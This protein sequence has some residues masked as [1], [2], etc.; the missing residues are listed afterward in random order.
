[1]NEFANSLRDGEVLCNLANQIYPGCIDLTQINKRS[2]MSQLLCLNNIRL[3]LD[4]CKS[5]QYFCLNESD[6]FDEHMLYDLVDL[7]C[8]IR[9]LSI[10]SNHK[11]TLKKTNITGFKLGNTKLGDI[12]L[13]L[14]S[15]LPI[16]NQ[17]QPQLQNQL[18][19]KPISEYSASINTNTTTTTNNNN[20]NDDIYYNIVPTEIES[21]ESFYTDDSFIFNG[22]LENQNGQS[23]DNSVY[24]TI[25]QSPTKQTT[26]QP[27]KRD[28]VIKEILNTEENFVDGLNTLMDDFL[29][30]LSKILNEQDRKLICINLDKLINLHKNLY[31]SLFNACKGGQGRTQ[32]ICTVFESFKVDL[33]KEYAEYFSNIDR[34]IAKCDSLTQCSL[35]QIND[36]SKQQYI[37]DFRSKLEECRKQSK[38]GNFKLTDLL[39]LPYQRVLKYH[40]LFN[41][42][43]KQ[44]DVEHSAKDIIKQTKE[45]MCE[46]GNYLNECQRDKEN[47][48]N[49]EQLLKHLL[50]ATNYNENNGTNRSSFGGSSSSFYSNGLNLNLL[51]DFGHYIKDD[52]L[53]IKSIDLGERSARTRTF[54]LFEKALIVCKLKG[55]YYNYKE[56]LIM[57]EYNI[58]DPQINSNQ[59]S[60]HNII[61]NLLSDLN[62]NSMNSHSNLSQ[63]NSSQYSL[64]LINSDRSKINLI[65]FKNKEQKKIWKQCLLMAKE[66]VKPNGSKMNKH[67]FELTNFD[68]DLVKCVVC[69]KYLLG[70]FYQGYRCCLC[71]S[72]AHKDCLSKMTIMCNLMNIP[73]PLPPPPSLPPSIQSQTLLNSSRSFSKLPER[74]T[75]FKDSSST[76][77]LLQPMIQTFCVRALH[78]YDGRPQPPENPILTFNQCDLIQVTDDDDDEWWKGFILNNKLINTKDEGYFPRSHVKIISQQQQQTQISTPPTP[79]TFLLPSNL[80]SSSINLEEYS[81]FA[82]VDRITADLILNRI[83]N[84]FSQ[85]IFMVRCRQEGG[86]A[87]SIKYNG[88]VDHIKINLNH[89]TTDHIND[90]NIGDIT[91]TLYAIDQ[92]RNFDSIVSLVNY[93]S[94][95]VLKENF[96]QLDTTLG[97]PYREALPMP[98]SFAIALHDYNPLIN[99]NNTGEQIELKKSS[100][101]FVLHKEMNGWWRVFNQDGLIGYVPGSYL[102]ERIPPEA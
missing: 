64:F 46:L 12:P 53:R 28:F 85:T 30:P 102:L 29:E 87:I 52:K 34:S 26:H 90:N 6:L 32:R 25:V 78:K 66:K 27:L 86:Y 50:V 41:E 4:S 67:L 22:L 79:I 10:L 59:T 74:S 48:S 18:S 68:R 98:I 94:Q 44:T 2:Q 75:S 37:L 96:P 65:I 8:V 80:S 99:P 82:P 15:S 36:Q 72:I 39:R 16:Q 56:T 45:S 17:Q 49:I 13:N 76:S 92:Q 7:A 88:F 100:K 14:R 83:P 54:F 21:P 58:E 62:Y 60:T 20:N 35:S 47:I 19:L 69:N 40:L 33:M 71:S 97:V 61:A 63:A 3:F 55:N 93:Y 42:L 57:N 89:L 1:M 11:Q 95:N 81:W 24:Q 91:K 101:Y 84:P 43:L 5:T 73:Q 70:V 23:N 51:K 9:T 38:R 77:R 31:N